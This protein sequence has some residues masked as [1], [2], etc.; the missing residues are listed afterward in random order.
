MM[1]GLRR[2]RSIESPLPERRGEESYPFPFPT[3]WSRLASTDSLRGRCNLDRLG[4]HIIDI[5]EDG[6]DTA[7]FQ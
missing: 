3:G 5:E 1:L 6:V 2:R 4:M 7:H